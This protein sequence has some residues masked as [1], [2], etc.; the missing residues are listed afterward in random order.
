MQLQCQQRS[1]VD[2]ARLFPLLWGAAG[3]RLN[4]PMAQ[5]VVFTAPNVV[6]WFGLSALHDSSHTVYSHKK[7]GIVRMSSESTSVDDILA[8]FDKFR[9]D[10]NVSG[11]EYA[12]LYQGRLPAPALFR[13]ELAA[14][15]AFGFTGVA[16][17]PPA[18]DP[19][20]PESVQGVNDG[21]FSA[22]CFPFAV[23]QH[24]TGTSVDACVTVNPDAS[25]FE[26]GY[27]FN[28]SAGASDAK[29]ALLKRCL[30]SIATHL[31]CVHNLSITGLSIRCLNRKLGGQRA[32]PGVT[33]QYIGWCQYEASGRD[34]P[35]KTFHVDPA[36]PTIPVDVGDEKSVRVRPL[37][38]VQNK[39]PAPAPV[40]LYDELPL[41]QPTQPGPRPATS[42]APPRVSMSRVGSASIRPRPPTEMG[43]A[44]LRS[45]AGLGR[46]MTAPARPGTRTRTPRPFSTTRLEAMTGTA[47]LLYDSA[48]L[49]SATAEDRLSELRHQRQRDN[50][51]Y[52]RGLFSDRAAPR[53][54]SKPAPRPLVPTLPPT[55]SVDLHRSFRNLSVMDLG[56]RGR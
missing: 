11:S 53:P 18:P 4:M 3:A 46:C 56:R 2:K 14:V 15:L 31:A 44:G 6:D 12:D 55:R 1:V 26:P 16:G 20:L 40:Q 28:I 7:R 49:D 50:Q 42:A 52:I 34:G 10:H 45:R 47:V 36:L 39:A 38:A 19:T 48:R 32:V 9:A 22:L 24:L 33:L 17:R 8:A 54:P 37:S 51:A 41:T 23:Q 13:H 43:R 29:Q 21:I 35:F 25:E 27:T 5:T 30:S